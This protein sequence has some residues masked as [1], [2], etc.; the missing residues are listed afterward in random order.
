MRVIKSETHT[1]WGCINLN[2]EFVKH[3]VL[4]NPADFSRSQNGPQF[5]LK[6]PDSQGR[7]SAWPCQVCPRHPPDGQPR[8]VSGQFGRATFL[9][10]PHSPSDGPS[11][12]WSVGDASST[13]PGRTEGVAMSWPPGPRGGAR[14]REEESHW[15][16]T[17]CIPRWDARNWGRKGKK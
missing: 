2:A 11:Q 4:V 8:V 10:S 6:T 15:L 7:L 16:P 5:R 14:V 3:K 17:S 12:A 9:P 1:K 13:P